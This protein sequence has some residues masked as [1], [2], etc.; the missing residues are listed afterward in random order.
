[1]AK[2]RLKTTYKILQLNGFGAF[3]CSLC[4][5]ENNTPKAY[6]IKSKFYFIFNSLEG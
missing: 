3:S 2:I 1:M 4:K 5:W 6:E